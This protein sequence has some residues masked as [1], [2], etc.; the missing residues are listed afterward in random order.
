MK[1]KLF[2]ALSILTAGLNVQASLVPVVPAT[3]AVPYFATTSARIAAAFNTPYLLPAGV[4]SAG[5]L[6]GMALTGST[7]PE[8]ETT[9]SVDFYET[10]YSNEIN[11]STLSVLPVSKIETLK[12]FLGQNKAATLGLSLTVLGLAGLVYKYG[13][14]PFGKASNASKA[15]APKPTVAVA[16]AVVQETP[17]IQ[18]AAQPV[19]KKQ[20]AK[21]F[22]SNYNR[23]IIYVK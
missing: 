9:S 23:K 7:T 6:V 15:S 12:A 3:L 2:L 20:A 22:R 1:N 13:K 14:N 5:S 8:T 16:P 19:V 17:V 18:Q 21:P 11:G 4:I 10:R